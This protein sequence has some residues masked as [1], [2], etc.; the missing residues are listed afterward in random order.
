MIPLRLREQK[1]ADIWR[2]KCDWICVTTNGHV[3]TSGALAMG[4]GIALDAKRRVR[5]CDLVLGKLVAKSGSHVYQF[6]PHGPFQSLV[7][8][9]TKHHFSDKSDL[10]LIDQ[11]C[12]ELLA[13]WRSKAATVQRAPV[14]A[15]PMVGCLNGGLDYAREVRPI[16][17]RHF[18]DPSLQAFF[19]VCIA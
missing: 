14:V 13:L 19:F 10:K 12:R 15:L 9:P 4:R 16:L 1:D 2:S 3:N 6:A 18:G 11:S 5:G 7:S 8:F 17:E